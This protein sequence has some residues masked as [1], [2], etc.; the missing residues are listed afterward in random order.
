ME[1]WIEYVLISAL[2]LGLYNIFKKKALEKN[3]AIEVLI[4]FTILSFIFV[5]PEAK[6]AFQTDL[7]Y[8]S[9]ILL[10]SV[11][12]F[13]SWIISWNCLKHMP[14]STYSIFYLSRLLFIAILGIILLQEK[15]IFIHLIGMILIMIGLI[16]ANLN[17]KTKTENFNTKYTYYLIISCF[18]ISFSSVIDK[19]VM[20][21]IN[22]GQM[23]FWFMG[24]MAVLYILYTIFT[25]AKLNF[26]T[27]KKNYWLPI[28]AISVIV[29]SRFHFMANAVPESN[30]SLI[31]FIRTLSVVISLLIGGLL[32]KEKNLLF[33]LFC[34]II[35]LIGI[36]LLTLY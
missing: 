4:T 27:I 3:N 25:K 12:V 30:I 34:S 5:I 10:K 33:K 20:K 32:F 24:F 29:A 16:I 31:A 8:I 35:I 9:I 11:I 17:Q 7:H 15:I 18:I 14:I 13:S 2:I 19:L 28:I 22:P 21:H 23:Q 36:A 1:L 26:N 6:N